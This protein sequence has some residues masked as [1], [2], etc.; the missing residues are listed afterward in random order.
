M[1]T[2]AKKLGHRVHVAGRGKGWVTYQCNKCWMLAT[3]ED[4]KEFGPLITKKCPGL[5]SY[6]KEYKMHWSKSKGK[7]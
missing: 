7:Q 5:Q 2:K 3:K 4:G 1:I 6:A